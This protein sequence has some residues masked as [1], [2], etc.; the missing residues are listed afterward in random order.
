MKKPKPIRRQLKNLFKQKR[1]L[2]PERRF[3]GL[4]PISVLRKKFS[5]MN[6]YKN[7]LSKIPC[8]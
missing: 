6:S 8:F 5:K 4:R 2:L 7:I 3:D 1:A